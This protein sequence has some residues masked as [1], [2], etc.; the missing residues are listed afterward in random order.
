MT[1]LKNIYDT[2]FLTNLAQEISKYDIDF[3]KENFVK[4]LLEDNWQD[5]ELKERMRAITTAIHSYLTSELLE[6]RINILKKT[7]SSIKKDKNSGLSLIIFSDYIEQYCHEKDYNLAINAL[8]FF[9]PIASSE[10]GIRKFIQIDQE[11]TLQH[12]LNFSKSDNYHV[13]RL[14]SEG[15]R[16]LLPWGVRLTELKNDPTN[17][18]PI[19]ENLKFDP[20]LYVR[21]SVA[22]NL[23][24]ISKDHPDLVV[25]LLTQWQKEGVDEY[26]IKHSLR[27]LLKQG[28][29]PALA[30]IGIK[31]D[32]K[33]Q[34]YEIKDFSLEKKQVNLGQNLAFSF[35]LHNLV[36]NNKIRLEYGVHFLKKNGHLNKKIFQ[37]T[38][39]N[40][41]KGCFEFRKKHLLKDLTTRKHYLGQHYIELIVNGVAVTKTNFD[42]K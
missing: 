25:T 40:F 20:Q 1:L 33:G 17:I 22:N 15:C 30:I 4:S 7:A 21:R 39:K 38:T 42:L 37:I 6:E 8:E 27:T 16:P 26:V 28:N 29:I 23:N 24:D 32:K 41:D 10:F 2:K 13:R 31:S 5:K 11:R 18:F 9:T 14:A 36:P 19:L 3:D 12:M 35:I 34:K